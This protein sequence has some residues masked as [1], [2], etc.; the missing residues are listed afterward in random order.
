MIRVRDLRVDYDNVCAVRD[1]SFDVTPGEVYGLIGPNGAGKTTIFRALLGLLEPTYGDIEINGIDIQVSP[2]QAHRTVGFMPDF[3]PLYEELMAWEFLDLFA[4]SYGIPREAR[5]ALVH[6][7]LDLVGLFEKRTALVGELSR[8]M[9][10]RLMLAKTL[11]PSP[12]VLLLDEPASGMDPHG[13]IMLKDI[14]RELRDKGKTVIV[15]SHI[16]AEMSEFCTSVGILEKGRMVV[17]GR[18]DDVSRQVVGVGSLV[19]E[20]LEEVETFQRI[21]GGNGRAGTVVRN[22]NVFE[23]P[24]AGDAHSDSELLRELVHAGVRVASFTRKRSNLEEI[25]LKV[26]AKELS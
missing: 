18:I 23:F 16:L 1:L 7:H 11:L 4:A 15:S 17:G 8:G 21:V 22:G 10:Q 14:L 5:P 20:V 25:F 3:S 19:V 26:G 12:S 6:S 9:R 2:E 13:R 24:C